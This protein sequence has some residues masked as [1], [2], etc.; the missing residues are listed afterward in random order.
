MGSQI[1]NFFRRNLMKKIIALLAAFL[2]WI[3][4]M[5]EQD[6]AITDSYTVP[7]TISNAPYELLYIIKEKDVR[8]ETR[9]P[10]SNY[11]K[12]G[13][14]AFRVYANLEGLG[15]GEHDITPQIVM[16]QGFEL[17]GIYPDTVKVKLEPLIERQMP[18]ELTLTGIV[19]QDSA[20]K[21]IR[22]S[23]E[24]VTVV[25]PKSYVEQVARVYSMVNLSG[26]TSSFELQIPMRA[27]DDKENPVANVRVVP[28]VITVS[29][30]IES[31]VRKKIVPVVTELTVSD[32]WELS[33]ITVEPAQIEIAG[34]ES[35]INSIV[36]LKT[37]PFIVQTGQKNFKSSL[38]LVVPEGVVVKDE[39]VT[40]SAE[41]I[42]KPTVRDQ[43]TN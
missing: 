26:N 12:Y 1:I 25:G 8:V 15:E 30:D 23:M 43:S 17:V 32:G 31:G 27:V 7:L 33:K 5:A 34:V 6:P 41:V 29:I 18:I 28:S 13:A 20:V 14:N 3:Y 24:T 36:T 35:V 2:M 21:E 40:V 42:R 10:R 37:E 38:R 22:K 19:G 11:I 4:V 9:A 16:P 39:E